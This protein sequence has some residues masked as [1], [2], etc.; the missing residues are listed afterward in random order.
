MKRVHVIIKGMVTGVF[1]RRFVKTNADKLGVK[2]YVRNLIDSV[3]ARF[4][5]NDSDVDELIELCKK[6]PEGARVDNV[7]V[8]EEKY[9]KEFEDFE[10]II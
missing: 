6:G 5:G 2:G 9:R 8:R 1:F 4:E 7:E 3:E 10:I